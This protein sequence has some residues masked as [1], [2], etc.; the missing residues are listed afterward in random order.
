MLRLFRHYRG[1]VL[2]YKVDTKRQTTS[3]QRKQPSCNSLID[4]PTSSRT[5]KCTPT[6]MSLAI[7]FTFCGHDRRTRPRKEQT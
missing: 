3:L 6:I 2:S 4:T 5:T 7:R 1:L